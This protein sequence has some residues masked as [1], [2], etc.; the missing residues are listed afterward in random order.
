[1]F[2]GIVECTGTIEAL[3]LSADR[4]SMTIRSH[5]IFDDL[6]IGDSI[7]VNG[8]CLT[9]TNLSD[10]KF[11][12]TIVPQTLRL[13]NLGFLSLGDEV[14][15]E[16][17][18]SACARISGHNVQG[19]IDGI[20]EIIEL[21][22]DGHEALLV[23]ISLPTSLAKYVVN[24]GYIALD[25]MSITVIE[26]HADWFTVTFIPYTKQVTIVK[27]YQ[28]GTKLNIEVDILSKA[29]E[30]ILRAGNYASTY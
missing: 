12:I 29:V 6:K 20:G 30:K 5:H 15:L 9:I 23:K 18:L 4:L 24:K 3:N 26:S 17:S 13:T 28:V 21:N 16:R 27:Q 25:G 14:N 10:D 8:T 7:S 22:K 19:H 1:M 2:N 11:D